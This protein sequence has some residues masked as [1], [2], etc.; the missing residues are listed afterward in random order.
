MIQVLQQVMVGQYEL[1]KWD[2]W[3]TAWNILVATLQKRLKLT[4]GCMIQQFT[5]SRPQD[6]VVYV[7]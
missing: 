5:Y 1:K 6:K 7:S 2:Y 4:L 3:N